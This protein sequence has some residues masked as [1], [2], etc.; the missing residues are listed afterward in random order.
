[1]P[2]KPVPKSD[3]PEQSR[4]FIEIAEAHKATKGGALKEAV[5]KLA[6]HGRE[7]PDTARAKPRKPQ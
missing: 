4:R 5:K 7:N 6:P 3:D 2:S 1:M